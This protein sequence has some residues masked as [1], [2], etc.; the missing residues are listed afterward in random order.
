[1]K[2]EILMQARKLQKNIEDIES[3]LSTI[4]NIKILNGQY[5]PFLR[6]ANILKRRDGKEVREASVLLFDGVSHH[7][8]TVPVEKDLLECIKAF[9]EKKL[10]DAKKKFEDL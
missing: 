1:M 5:E 2:E 7:G 10:L 9:Y 8:T 6:F 3:V 4:K